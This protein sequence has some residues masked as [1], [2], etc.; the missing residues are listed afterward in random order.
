MR[1]IIKAI[2]TIICLCAVVFLAG[3]WPEDTPRKKVITYDASALAVALACGL[4][5]KSSE[6]KEHINHD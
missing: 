4:Y 2:V 5:L 6:T 3:E 1:N